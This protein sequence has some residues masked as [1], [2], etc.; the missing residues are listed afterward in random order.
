M[1][2]GF[3]HVFERTGLFILI[4]LIFGGA[5]AHAQ[6]SGSG[7]SGSA[8][9]GNSDSATGEKTETNST[10]AAKKDGKVAGE[11]GTEA[12]TED[13][14]ADKKKVKPEKEVATGGTGGAES[15]DDDGT[16][17]DD[18]V[19]VEDAVEA[20]AA[21]AKKEGL[22]P[23]L[24]ELSREVAGFASMVAEYRADVRRLVDAQYTRRKLKIQKRYERIIS[25]LTKLERER[26]LEAI[27]RFEMF[28]AKYPSNPKYT[29]DALFRL[30]ELYFEKAN[31]DF[32][33]LNEAYEEQ[34]AAFEDGK[35]KVEPDPPTKSYQKTVA[36]FSK[37]I[38]SW[39]QYRNIDGALYLKGYCLSEMGKDTEAKDAFQLLVNRFPKS[40]FTPEA[41]TRLGEFYFDSNR[42]KDA[43]AAYRKVLAFEGHHLYDEAL[44]KLAWTYFRDDQYDEAIAG[45]RR[46]IE[47][48]D[49]EAKATGRAGTELRAEAIQYLA[50]SLQEED[51]DGDGERDP[52]AGFPRVMSY[53]SGQK[54]Y[55]VEILRA[56]SDIFFENAKYEET[57]ATINHLLKHFPNHPDNPDLHSRMVTAYERLQRFDEAF[58]ER[59]K[60]ATKYGAGG[61]WYRR[62]Q[63]NP[64]AIQGADELMQDA[65]SQ[66]AQYHHSK[67][68]RHRDD[69]AK[70]VAN[71]QALA[72][73]EYALAAEAY[74]KYLARF[75]RTE[76]AYDL[77]FFYAECLYY[78]GKFLRAAAQYA[79]VRDSK[80]GK[81]YLEPSGYYAVVSR[82]MS[83]RDLI[84]AGKVVS[85]PSLSG[86]E[87]EVTTDEPG[88]AD[89]D[90]DGLVKEIELEPIPEE[91]ARLIEARKAYMDLKLIST[92]DKSRRPRNIFK[93]AE[94]Y[95]DFKHFDTA[96]K[97]FA[98]LI[99]TYPKEKVTGNAA[100]L[101]VE[102]YRQ[103]N[104]WKKMAKWAE[105]IAAAGLGREFDE[106][107][108]T[109]KVGALFKDAE[110]LQKSGKLKDAAAEY[111]RLVDENP[112]NKFAANALNNAAVA[113]ETLRMFESATRAY[114]RIYKGY[115]KSQFVEDALFRVGINSERFYDFQKA[116]DTHLKLV[117]QFPQSA[118]RADSLYKAAVLQERTQQYL[119]A[120]ANFERYAQL[121]PNRKDTA[122][123]FFRAGDTYRKL[124]DT[125]NEIR[126]YDRFAREYGSDPAQNPLVVEGLTRVAKIY[127]AQGKKRQAAQTWQRVIDEFNSRG[128]QPATY[129]ANYPAEASFRLVERDFVVYERLKISGSMKNQGRVIKDMTR[130]L[131]ELERRY[132]EVLQYRADTWSIAALYRIGHIYQLFAEAFYNAPI[133]DTLSE[134]EQDVYRTMLEDQA[135]PVEDKA[136]TKYK[137]AIKKARELKIVNEWTKRILTSLNKYLPSDYPL[138]KEEL[139]LSAGRQLTT[140]RM[141]NL[142]EPKSVVTD[143]PETSGP[144]EPK[145]GGETS[146]SNASS[147][148]DAPNVPT[149]AN[150]SN[151][152]KQ[153][154]EP[155]VDKEEEK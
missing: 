93:M 75:P 79:R 110:R 131:K 11:A 112:G 31:D 34:A 118:N 29:P 26:R 6:V 86:L 25:D 108:R 63:D 92:E 62:N 148:E 103:A 68:Q 23:E 32:L 17:S 153:P 128:M 98:F 111:L 30:A 61:E 49:K 70:G 149:N 107:I 37:L 146:D 58:A 147:D 125:R 141:I 54:E 3:C 9:P 28:L 22:P 126:V 137:F 82:Q 132:S 33:A 48:S 7:D 90:N 117:S 80:L 151:N 115:P 39:P 40:K 73:A 95:F 65:L 51:W 105:K 94:I 150:E 47:F 44:Y 12:K 143:T 154:K 84:D 139:R 5:N 35:S 27:K 71:A 87:S 4:S 20:A 106:E 19:G 155:G 38:S 97:W 135:M 83:V 42:L 152:R 76:N 1:N 123:T 46:L 67:A 114:E 77:N 64:E 16:T 52:G 96:R 43:I 88:D 14:K 133:P 59:D 134:E 142:G 138:F 8:S 24:V 101:M 89:S 119:Q 124:K 140:P 127:E 81:K 109:L 100:K 69:I 45:F 102:T 136:V 72:M 129:E 74:E 55:D 15:K 85:K 50:V 18:I 10:A 99:E 13:S 122:E 41:W 60:L 130:R 2:R 78:S 21:R 36:L 121:F 120:A 66:A 91:V 144:V 104:D 116:I 145:Q 56:L 57:I 113:Y 53:V